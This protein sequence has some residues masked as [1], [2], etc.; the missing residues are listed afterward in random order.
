MA[1]LFLNLFAVREWV[2]VWLGDRAGEAKASFCGRWAR[3]HCL[4]ARAV[5]GDRSLIGLAVFLFLGR[6]VL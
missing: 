1:L 2:G 5:T 4:E 6:S 3:S